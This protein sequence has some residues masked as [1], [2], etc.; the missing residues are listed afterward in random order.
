MNWSRAVIGERW[1]VGTV[2]LEVS[3]PRAPCW[4]L[5]HKMGDP[6]FVRRFT[7]AGRTGAYL[8][9][10]TEGDLGAGDMLHRLSEPSHGTTIGDVFRIYSRDRHEA[11]RLVDIPELSESWRAWAESQL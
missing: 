11:A 4:K 6:K 7:E 1:R 10:H 8:R 2:E 3:E 9:I 5:A